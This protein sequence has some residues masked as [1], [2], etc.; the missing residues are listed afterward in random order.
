MSK[1]LT[2]KGLAFGA[3]V[4]LGSSVVAGA[5]ANAAVSNLA[6]ASSYGTSLNAIL[7]QGFD[8][9][10][11]GT[12]LTTGTGDQIK[13]YIE[14]ATAAE[15]NAAHT[16]AVTDKTATTAY[17]STVAPTVVSDAEKTAVFGGTGST[18]LSLTAGNY[19]QYR[20][21]LDDADVSATRSIKVTP[22]IDSEIFDGKPAG[23]EVKG[24][25][26]TINFIKASEITAITKLSTT[27]GSRDAVATVTLDKDI[28]LE[29]IRHR[30]GTTTQASTGVRSGADW[31]SGVTVAFKEAG[32]ALSELVAVYSS[33]SSA[34]KASATLSVGAVATSLYTAQAKINGANSGTAGSSSVAAGTVDVTN[35][36][37]AKTK[38]TES[39]NV[40]DDTNGGAQSYT[41]R[42]GTGSL[43]F[44]TDA[45]KKNNDDTSAVA[46]SVG[47][48]LPAKVT[49]AAT[50]L[51]TGSTYSVG[52]KTINADVTSVSFDTTTNADG[53]V[54]FDLTGTGA[55]N[56]VLT[57]VVSVLDLTTYAA[58]GT[59]TVKWIDATLDHIVNLNT[60]QDNAVAVKKGGSFTL[61][62]VL[63]DNFG[64][65]YAGTDRR[66]YFT[67]T[68][69]TGTSAA[70]DTYSL[71]ADGKATVTLND[72]NASIT[73]DSTKYYGVTATV[74]KESAGSWVNDTNVQAVE[75]R[76]YPVA[77][78]TVGF[79]TANKSGSPTISYAT[80]SA[81]D[82]RIDTNTVSF[83]AA[84]GTA[85]VVSG[86]AYDENGS[87]LTGATVTVAAAGLEFVALNGANTT[88]STVRG[89][90]SIT[91]TTDT[92]GQYAVAAYSNKSGEQAITVTAGSITKT[93]T[94]KWAA[95]A[96]GKIDTINITAPVSAAPGTTAA[97]VIKTT[98]KYGNVAAAN[99]TTTSGGT[100]FKVTITGAGV[101]ST[102]TQATDADGLLKINQVLGSGETGSFTVKVEF[103]ADGQGTIGAGSDSAAISKSAV[104]TVA[105]AA[106]PV[107]V[108]PT[109]KI[110]TANSRVYVN[111]KDGKGSVVSVKIGTKW[112]TKTSLNN[113]YTFSFKAKKKSKV[114]V[115][116]YVDGDLSSSKTITVK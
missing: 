107:A 64:K 24:N 59:T 41:V 27:V 16:R 101:S 21:E 88:T 11:T 61:N 109:S 79:L 6:I 53:K 58:L 81:A 26:L 65:V 57:V 93:V 51:G 30:S 95:A 54:A 71:V 115:K 19:N 67:A 56:D 20:I 52:G 45:I 37:S 102:F 8:I 70:I 74:K 46:V 103:D 50:T 35:S 22:F 80:L 89:M 38:L 60:I 28:N 29:Q 105:A 13:L 12:G 55:K 99:N 66:V 94:P 86:V 1:N 108:E 40:N 7:G 97:I 92:S 44:A 104:V 18:G 78:T 77:S 49:V 112:F 114:S 32:S 36:G 84:H 90:G 82:G 9:S 100:A 116:V 31:N 48:G 113:D 91:V 5:P 111:V 98:D 10:L 69:V 76:V 106:A 43:A 85:A 62:Y 25:T 15:L 17:G 2:R 68:N 23:N 34:L 42:T 39:V 96:A 14:G 47:A 73:P 33:G 83:D 4:A 75:T 3:L 110:G 63:A 72:A 87:A